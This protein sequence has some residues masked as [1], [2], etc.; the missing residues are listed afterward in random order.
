MLLG[1][2][3]I[4]TLAAAV[5]LAKSGGWA[6]AAGLCVGGGVAWFSA[7]QIAQTIVWV[8]MPNKI[9]IL[10]AQAVLLA[11]AA[12]GVSFIEYTYSRGDVTV[13]PLAWIGLGTAIGLWH[14]FTIRPAADEVDEVNQS[15]W[16]AQDMAKPGAPEFLRFASGSKWVNGEVARLVVVPAPEGF[17]G[18]AVVAAI[19]DGDWRVVSEGAVS[20]FSVMDAG[21]AED[22][23]LEAVGLPFPEEPFVETALEGLSEEEPER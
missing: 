5:M 1:F 9:K 21:L 19:W 18:E 16:A 10:L 11:C 22:E 2:Y 3:A 17:E 14:G 23:D 4:S 15:N 20:V 8:R 7:I 13:T 12:W 6:E